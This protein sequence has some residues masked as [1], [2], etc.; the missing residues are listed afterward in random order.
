MKKAAGREITPEA[1]KQ[2]AR[3]I[4]LVIFDVD[5]VLTDGGIILDGDNNE[6][7]K[8]NVRDGHGIKL[9][10]RAGIE[11]AL[12]TGRYSTVV[13]KRAAELGIK[14]VYQRRIEKT[15]AYEEL[16]VKLALKAEETA[17]VGDDI[18]DIPVLMRAGLPVAVADAHDEAKKHALM[19][20]AARGGFG[21]AREC[22]EFILK[23]KGL[24][25]EIIDAY[26]KI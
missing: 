2:R 17:Y 16:L 12:I 1:L 25:N 14:E 26:T 15:G 22:V 10:Q 11:V 8:F 19:I 18:L 3:R 6:Y 4:K 13:E 20:T 5:G 9:L 24:W 23:A 7:K 21:A